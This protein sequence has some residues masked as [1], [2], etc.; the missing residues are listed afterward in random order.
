MGL[1]PAEL[2]VSFAHDACEKSVVQ[3]RMIRNS[4]VH[5]LYEVDVAGTHHTRTFNE[6]FSL[7]G[8]NALQSVE[9]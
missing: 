3:C 5:K 7:L 6:E 1:C 8:C 9:S 2:G 4:A